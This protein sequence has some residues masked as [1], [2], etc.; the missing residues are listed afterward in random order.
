MNYKVKQISVILGDLGA[1]I[2]GLWIALFL[3]EG[4]VPTASEWQRHLPLFMLV[5]FLWLLIHFMIGL[6]D[7]HKVAHKPILWKRLSQ[8]GLLA[9]VTG[10]TFFYLAPSP[11]ITPKTILF[12]TVLF[13]YFFL[14]LLRVLSHPLWKGKAYAQQILFVGYSKEVEEIIT[15]IQ[16]NIPQQYSIIGLVDEKKI[17]GIPHFKSIS[18]INNSVIHDQLDS[19]IVAPRQ[20]NDDQITSELY[21]FLFS[22]INVIDLTAFY[23]QLMGRVPP[24]V[25]SESWF[26]ENLSST[27]QAVYVKWKKIIDICAGLIIGSITL[28]CFPIIAGAIKVTSKGPIFFSQK[29]VGLGG[30]EFRIYKF[31]SMYALAP[32]GSAEANGAQFATKE[33]K[34]ITPIG[35]ILRKTRLD[36]LPQ[37]WNLLKGDITLIGPRPERPELV[38]TLTQMMPYYSLRHIVKPGLTG[39]AVI[40]Q[41]YADSIQKSLSKLQYDLYYIKHRTILLDIEIVL[42]TIR[43]LLG[44]KGQ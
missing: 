13:G 10:T 37:V 40:H 8:A 9:F 38:T 28:I 6:Y 32:D 24:V 23:E 33:D 1:L 36:E 41:N 42:K 19:I 25:F 34:R 15:Y 11:T 7:L 14:S 20:K 4:S 21:Q 5:F 22:S 26:M 12:L 16:A 2:V 30:K 3:R 27:D 43:L 44:A 29:R 31:R 17:P 39:W 35:K 18:H